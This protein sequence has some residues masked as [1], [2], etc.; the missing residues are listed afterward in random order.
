MFAKSDISAGDFLA[1]YEGQIMTTD[2]YLSGI[3]DTYVYEFKFKEKPMW[4]VY[5]FIVQIEI[6]CYE[7]FFTINFLINY[8]FKFICWLC[9]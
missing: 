9:I 4:Y 1:E 8:I 7:S 6:Y 3:S 2:P 5:V